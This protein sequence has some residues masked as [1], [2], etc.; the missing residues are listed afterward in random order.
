MTKVTF[1]PNCTQMKVLRT[2]GCKLDNNLFTFVI[3][4]DIYNV[5]KFY[6]LDFLQTF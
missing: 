6:N 5:L 1:N 2:I 4:V 3:S